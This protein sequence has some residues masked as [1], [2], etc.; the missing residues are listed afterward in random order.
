MKTLSL[1]HIDAPI[2]SGKSVK[3]ERLDKAKKGACVA[4]TLLVLNTV[5]LLSGALEDVFSLEALLSEGLFVEPV[6]L[7]ITEC[8][9]YPVLS[10]QLLSGLCWLLF[11]IFPARRAGIV[12]RKAAFAF[13]EAKVIYLVQAAHVCRVPPRCL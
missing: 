6:L 7:S 3:C 5:M 12:L 8:L 2:A 4:L 13:T 9:V 10:C 1:H 11:H